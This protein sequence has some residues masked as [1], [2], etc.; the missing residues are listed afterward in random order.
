MVLAGA[1]LLARYGLAPWTD[2]RAIVAVNNLYRDSRNL[3]VSVS[4]ASDALLDKLRKE[5]ASDKRFPRISKGE[6]LNAD[7]KKEIWGII[8]EIGGDENITA[9]IPSR[10]ESLVEPSAVSDLVLRE[11][12]DRELLVKDPD[13]NL[14]RQVLIKGLTNK[15]ARYVCIKGLI[16]RPPK[17][18][19]KA[20]ERMKAP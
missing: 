12:D 1:R 13:E 19:S 3:T 6:S 18:K 17:A 4:Q 9:V 10:F 7:R 5:V 14:K 20:V 2:Q 15:R 16:D 8:R 11:L